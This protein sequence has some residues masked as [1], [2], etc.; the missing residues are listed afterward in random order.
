MHEGEEA[1]VGAI[2]EEEPET[3]GLARPVVVEDHRQK[4]WRLHLPRVATVS[5]AQS[6]SGRDNRPEM[7]RF[8][9]ARC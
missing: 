8:W 2:S 1:S 5:R 3:A 6:Q 9:G 7:A 4:V